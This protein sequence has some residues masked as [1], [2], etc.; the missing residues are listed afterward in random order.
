M[1]EQG[2]EVTALRERIKFL[3]NEIKRLQRIVDNQPNVKEVKARVWELAAQEYHQ[4]RTTPFATF[5]LNKAKA[6]REGKEH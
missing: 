4:T 5:C 2:N 6:I 3:T 1:I